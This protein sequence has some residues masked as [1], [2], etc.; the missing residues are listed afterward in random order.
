M[1]TTL[2]VDTFYATRTLIG[3]V[4]EDI[5][6]EYTI[7]QHIAHMHAPEDRQAARTEVLAAYGF[8]SS[9]YG[10]GNEDKFIE[11]LTTGLGISHLDFIRDMRRWLAAR[12]PR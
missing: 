4:A 12:D 5:Q 8:E 6:N 9:G 2:S 10:D 11:H 3:R 7:L 1:S